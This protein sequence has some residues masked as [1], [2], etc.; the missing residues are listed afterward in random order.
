MSTFQ[1]KIERLQASLDEKTKSVSAKEKC[2]PTLLVTGIA[3]PFLLF[4]I[5]F[6]LKPSFVQK[7]EGNKYVRDHR[8]IFFYSMALTLLVWLG[9]YLYSYCIGYSNAGMVCTR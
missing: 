3:V 7:Q 5:L 1:E 2:F 4:I 8:K 6:F 9:M